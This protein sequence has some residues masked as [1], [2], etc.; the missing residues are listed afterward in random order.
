MKYADCIIKDT[1]DRD[2][3][4]IRWRRLLKLK[5]PLLLPIF[6]CFWAVFPAPSWA[7]GTPDAQ[8]Q[9]QEQIFLDFQRENA[10]RFVRL[11]EYL[12]RELGKTCGGFL[13]N[14]HTVLTSG[15]CIS[16]RTL[17][18]NAFIKVSMLAKRN[19]RR[20]PFRVE[21]L[22]VDSKTFSVLNVENSRN[23]G[24]FG[25]HSQEDLALV[26]LPQ[27]YRPDDLEQISDFPL[28]NV[29]SVRE[30]RGDRLSGPTQVVGLTNEAL[31]SLQIGQ[32][33]GAEFFGR[34]RSTGGE[35]LTGP[36]REFVADVDR[37]GRTVALRP[38]TAPTNPL[39]GLYERMGLRI[40]LGPRDFNLIAQNEATGNAVE[41]DS[42]SPVF[43]IVDG[44]V[45]LVGTVSAI[46]PGLEFL[47][48]SGDSG[49]LVMSNQMVI[50][51]DLSAAPASGFVIPAIA[52]VRD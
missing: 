13:L 1:L 44:K 26:F 28:T 27:R 30:S 24:M 15:H 6:V 14:E 50:A 19:V 7:T 17:E 11:N 45:K 52:T 25:S 18:Q 35:L 33:L 4:S 46:V 42:G 40:P 49:P 38:A 43:A 23:G 48:F 29:A 39:D 32:D 37:L 41:G 12:G 36:N 22:E 47:Y 10:F 3:R 5:A 2:W 21:L 34:F 31:S 51:T 9:L 20:Q 8:R 16:Q